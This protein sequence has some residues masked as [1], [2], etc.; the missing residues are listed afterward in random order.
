M[1]NTCLQR[2]RGSSNTFSAASGDELFADFTGAFTSPTTAEGT[3]TFTGGT[4]RFL[5]ATG[6]A[7]F[8]AVGVAPGR[9][10][11]TFQGQ[12]QY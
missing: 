5:N 4:G 10:R 7:T 1:P 8:S 11:I 12:I 2:C 3:Y 9:F 6:S